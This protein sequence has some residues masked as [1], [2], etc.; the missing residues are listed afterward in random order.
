MSEEESYEEIESGRSVIENPLGLYEGERNLAGDRHGNGKALLPNGDMYSGHYCQGLRQGH[1]TYVFAKS[2]ARYEGEWRRNSKHGCGSFIYPDG[3]RYEGEWKR[4]MRHGIGAYYYR[5]G[6][7]YKGSWKRGYRHGLGTYTYAATGSKFYGN[8]IVDR[9]H[10]A[11]QLIHSKHRFHGFWDTNLPVGR[12]CYIFEDGS[13]QHGYYAL[14][15][16]DPVREETTASREASVGEDTCAEEAAEKIMTEK[17]EMK[18]VPLRT[19]IIPVWRARCVTAYFPELLPPEPKPLPETDSLESLSD[20]CEDDEPCKI[21]Y[22][23]REVLESYEG[24]T[25]D[26][27]DKYDYEL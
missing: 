27:N 11:G 9:M 10:G 20:V 22:L 13:M 18:P 21:K 3:T 1:G 15:S 5:N 4:D 2:G 7:V 12:G 17:K 19:G 16:V 25:E 14:I 26:E 6:D 24:E 8:W 23:K